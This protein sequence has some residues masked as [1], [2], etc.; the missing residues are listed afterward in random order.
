M[1]KQAARRRHLVEAPYKSAG[2]PAIKQCERCGLQAGLHASMLR[3]VVMLQ[4]GE[5]LGVGP[6]L[7]V[8]H[9]RHAGQACQVPTAQTSSLQVCWQAA[10]GYSQ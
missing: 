3:V 7:W 9:A 6:S 8:S 1:R 10:R 2:K 4:R 5:C